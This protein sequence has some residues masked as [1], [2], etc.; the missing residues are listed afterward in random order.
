MYDQNGKNIIFN[1][2]DCFYLLISAAVTLE[3]HIMN[4]ENTSNVLALQLTP[5]INNFL[6]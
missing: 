1:V 4:G 2:V 5:G 6:Q 3:K